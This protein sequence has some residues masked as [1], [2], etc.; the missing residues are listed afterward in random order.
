MQRKNKAGIR[1]G[2]ALVEFA[3]VVPIF[4]FFASGVVEVSRVLLLQNTVDTAA[5]EGARHAMVPGAT[6]EEA[7]LASQDLLNSAGLKST[8]ITVT[9]DVIT[10]ETAFISVQVA[11]P[12][13]SNSWI[14]PTHF[15][16]G[17][18]VTSEVTLVCERPPL[19][20]LTG[21][22]ALKAKKSKGSKD[23]AL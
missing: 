12:V 1:T 10:E 3:L 2:A 21:L 14:A 17:M 15:F 16:A 18:T 13:A 20:R 23:P 6:V 19:V 9:P 11:V 22:P 4:V 7:E 5:Y 8:T